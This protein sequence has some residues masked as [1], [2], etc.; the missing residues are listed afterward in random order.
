MI[1]RAVL[2]SSEASKYLVEVLE[3]VSPSEL[4]DVIERV[5]DAVEKQPCKYSAVGPYRLQLN[6]QSAAVR[7]TQCV[8]FRLFSNSVL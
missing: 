4:D 1:F 2:C 7:S 5:L 6:V 8:S 3:A